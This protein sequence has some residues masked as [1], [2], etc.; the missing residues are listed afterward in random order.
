M[1]GDKAK[2]EEELITL[3]GPACWLADRLPGHNVLNFHILTPVLASRDNV[4]PSPVGAVDRS[5]KSRAPNMAPFPIFPEK[6]LKKIYFLP[7]EIE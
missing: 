6:Q 3:A 1:K 5:G 4:A 2:A 7:G